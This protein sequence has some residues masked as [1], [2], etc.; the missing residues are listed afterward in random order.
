M[1]LDSGVLGEGWLLS[2]AFSA[3]Q[4]ST[5]SFIP[6]VLLLTDHRRLGLEVGVVDLVHFQMSGN[7]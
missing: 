3:L 2:M 5:E 1:S 4:P 7:T 6:R